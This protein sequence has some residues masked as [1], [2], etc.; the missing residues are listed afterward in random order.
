MLRCVINPSRLEP[1]KKALWNAGY[2]SVTVTEAQGLG[3]QKS[4]LA[5]GEEE[6]VVEFSPRVSVEV[7]APDTHVERLVELVLD[8]IRTGRVGDGKIFITALDQVVRVRT[9][10]RGDT[11]L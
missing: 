4:R 8:S 3:S 11:A 5:G 7:A 6:H 9:G 10:E 1:L 2:R